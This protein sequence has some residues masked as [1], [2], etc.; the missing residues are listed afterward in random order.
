MVYIQDNTNN[1]IRTR[2]HKYEADC[3]DNTEIEI[4]NGGDVTHVRDDEHGM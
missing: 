4:M 1:K 3:Q 2:A